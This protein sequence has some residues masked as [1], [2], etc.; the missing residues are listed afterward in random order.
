MET[1][2]KGF[3]QIEY[4]NNYKREKYDRIEVVLPKGRKEELKRKAK[5]KGMSMSEYINSVI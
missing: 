5:E 3:N 1:E 2:K 4:Q